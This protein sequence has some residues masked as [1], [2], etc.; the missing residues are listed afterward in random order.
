MKFAKCV[1]FVV[2]LFVVA[3]A[4]SLKYRNINEI[5]IYLFVVDVGKRPK[6]YY[7][8]CQLIAFLLFS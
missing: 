4:L 2:D 5:I 6:Y 8:H 7:N 3:K 1:P